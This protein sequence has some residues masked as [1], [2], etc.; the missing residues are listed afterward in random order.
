MGDFGHDFV[1]YLKN[2]NWSKLVTIVKEN[3]VVKFCKLKSTLLAGFINT[4]NQKRFALEMDNSPTII[5]NKTVYPTMTQNV[6]VILEK[7]NLE[8]HEVNSVDASMFFQSRLEIVYA[9]SLEETEDIWVEIDVQKCKVDHPR[10]QLKLS[11]ISNMESVVLGVEAV[12][13]HVKRACGLVYLHRCAKMEVIVIE[14]TF[15]TEEVPVRLGRDGISALKYTHPITR[16]FYTSFTMTEYN[17]IYPNVLKLANG[18]WITYGKTK[19]RARVEPA[20]F[21]NDTRR[22]MRPHE[23]VGLKENG[24]LR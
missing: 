24:F 17:S 23:F 18:T 13:V 20:P 22:E 15:C 21:F 4:D 5:C 12:V 9:R 6:Y 10:E 11:L 19:E 1:V 2:Y 16:V 14:N 7:W 8:I 3:E